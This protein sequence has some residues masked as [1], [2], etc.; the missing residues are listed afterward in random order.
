MFP[1]S[2]CSFILLDDYLISYL[3]FSQSYNIGPYSCT[4][5]DFSSY[6]TKSNR[7]V[8]ITT[9]TS[10]VHL[11]L[12]I[13]CGLMDQFLLLLFQVNIFTSALNL[14]PSYLLLFFDPQN[15]PSLFSVVIF[16]NS[17]QSFPTKSVLSPIFKSNNKDLS[18]NPVFFQLQSFESFSCTS[19]HASVNPLKISECDHLSQCLLLSPLCKLAIFVGWIL[20]TV[21]IHFP[22]STSPL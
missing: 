20:A 1:L 6:F 16:P 7:L 15:I 17:N 3:L 14:I 8:P 22:S 2:I 11:Y 4:I 18:S 10:H 12:Y 19:I 13:L 5:D 21:L 9:S